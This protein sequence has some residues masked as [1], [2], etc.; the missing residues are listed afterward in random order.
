MEAVINA[1]RSVVRCQLGWRQRFVSQ[2]ET[3]GRRHVYAKGRRLGS[4]W[5]YLCEFSGVLR[6]LMYVQN[7]IKARSADGCSRIEDRRCM[8][9]ATK[10]TEPAA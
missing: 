5:W 1:I 6:A 4:G 3:Q 9:W 10:S 8:N 7:Y 2:Q